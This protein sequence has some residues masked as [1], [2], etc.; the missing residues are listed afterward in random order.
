MPARV[1]GLGEQTEQ[2]LQQQRPIAWRPAR[3]PM[4]KKGAE[5][6][7]LHASGDAPLPAA[8]AGRA[9]QGEP[10]PRADQ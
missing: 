2:R 4:K 3:M 9:G 1:G 10:E 8:C 7:R 6:V 5:S